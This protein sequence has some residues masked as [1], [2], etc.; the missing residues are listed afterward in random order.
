MSSLKIRPGIIILFIALLAF[1]PVKVKAQ[2]MTDVSR[3]LIC[4]C[5][6]TLVLS[7]CTH[8]ECGSREIITNLLN[9]KLNQGQSEAA[10]IQ[11]FVTQYGEQVL[12]APPKKGFNLAAWVTPFAALLFGVGVV[13]VTLKRWVR[14]EKQNHSSVVIEEDERYT[15]QLEK[16]LKE[17]NERSFR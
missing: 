4:Q 13:Y 5:G 17:F 9:E 10:I 16:E 2:S 8:H 3:Q 1:S 14:R 15:R 12:S 7:N 11:F 6:C